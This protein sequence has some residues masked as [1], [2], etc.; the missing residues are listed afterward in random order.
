VTS[1]MSGV[2]I[3]I[4]VTL[5]LELVTGSNSKRWDKGDNIHRSQVAKEKNAR[6][7]GSNMLV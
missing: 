6:P 3:Q 1:S 2:F 7:I 4:L 5:N